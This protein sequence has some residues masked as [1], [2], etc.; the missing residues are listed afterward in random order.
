VRQP[1]A[2]KGVSVDEIETAGNRAAGDLA[3]LALAPVAPGVSVWWADL[4]RPKS[5]IAHFA[6]WLSA[7]EHARATRFGTETLRH[8]YIAGRGTLRIL[9]GRALGMAPADVGIRRGTRGRPE[10]ADASEVLDFNVSHTRD[11][12]VIGIARHMPCGARIGVDVEWL[13][14]EVGVDRLARKF[15]TP[16]ERSTLPHLGIDERRRRFLRLWTC[17]EAM[18]KATA[19]GLLAPFRRLDVALDEPLRLVAGP[20]PYIPSEWRLHP[21]PVPDGYLATLAVWTGRHWMPRSRRG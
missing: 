13:D 19:D 4:D 12:A 6:A 9:L 2:E 1:T 15:L 11:H 10:L 8:K 3:P 20:A 7:A 17:K 16:A 18:S 14:R 5:E 21:L